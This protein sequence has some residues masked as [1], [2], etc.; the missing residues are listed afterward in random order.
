MEHQITDRIAIANEASG[1]RDD[2]QVRTYRFMA[3]T[4]FDSAA[5]G[6]LK[7]LISESIEDANND[8]T[9]ELL[10]KAVEHIDSAIEALDNAVRANTKELAKVKP[11]QEG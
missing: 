6:E 4:L 1:P 8:E 11:E 9:K 5:L 7:N 3:A 10:G 2:I